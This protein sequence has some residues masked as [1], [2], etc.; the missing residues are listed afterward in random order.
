MAGSSSSMA[1][2]VGRAQPHIPLILCPTCKR[3]EVVERTSTIDEN[4]GRVFF[5]C[6][7]HKRRSGCPFFYWE[8]EYVELLKEDGLEVPEDPQFMQITVAPEASRRLRKGL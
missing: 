2:T 7:Y 5:T 4:P 6:P 1:S 8:D 3:K